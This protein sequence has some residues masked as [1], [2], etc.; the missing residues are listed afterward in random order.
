MTL[1]SAGV[2][3]YSRIPASQKTLSISFIHDVGTVSAT[4]LIIIFTETLVSFFFI[5]VFKSLFKQTSSPEVFFIILA[6]AGV[7]FGAFRAVVYLTLIFSKIY[8][9][10]TILPRLV[11]FGKLL[12]ALALFVS[13][14]FSTG[15]RLQKQSTFL[16]LIV[17]FALLL[18]TTV[19]IDFSISSNILLPGN[20][21]PYIMQ[22]IVY[23]LYILA[24]LNYL[25]GAYTNRNR[26]FII[27]GIGL[28][29]FTAGLEFIFPFHAGIQL[30]TGFTLFISGLTLTAYKINKIYNWI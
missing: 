28:G 23:S 2:L 27:A 7:S 14:L 30:F 10:Y 1:L 13:G 15:F 22:K 3:A 4:A 19:P 24:L 8:I 21:S 17:I 12:S 29:M 18:S 6:L 25:A 16:G 11:Y 20:G 5:M 9:L 26:D